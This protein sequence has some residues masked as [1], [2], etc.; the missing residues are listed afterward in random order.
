MDFINITKIVTQLSY[1][2]VYTCTVC[3]LVYSRIKLSNTVYVKPTN[4]LSD[5]GMKEFLTDD[6]KLPFTGI[7]K[8]SKYAGE[9]IKYGQSN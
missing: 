8:K 4:L 9:N 6:I 2:C 1:T 7:L 5:N 3:L